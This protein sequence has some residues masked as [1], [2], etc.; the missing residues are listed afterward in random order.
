M[1]S[2]PTWIGY[3]SFLVSIFM[4]IVAIAAT[5]ISYSVYY[6]NSN[7]DVIVH[8]EQNPESKT[9]L[10]LII[11]N[12]GNGSA[13]NISFS[14]EK[15]LPQE[16]FNQPIQEMSKGPIITGIP[17][18]A[19]GSSRTLML[20]MYR[21]LEKWLNDESIIINIECERKSPIFGLTKK[22]YTS[23]SIDVY[24]FLAVEASDN[25]NSKKNSRRVKES[26]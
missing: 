15:P 16:A 10:N 21:G 9:V 4:A 20:G 13:K 25:S 8:L 7:P 3:G 11:E 12:I 6:A 26:K 1:E 14:T 17:Y 19:P 18:L 24:S 5:S 22:V 2:L 23:S